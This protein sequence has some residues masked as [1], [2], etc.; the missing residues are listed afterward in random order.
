MLRVLFCMSCCSAPPSNNRPARGKAN[1]TRKNEKLVEEADFKSLLSLGTSEK[2]SL[3]TNQIQANNLNYGAKGT[4]T[5]GTQGDLIAG[6]ANASH[7]HH[8]LDQQSK[9]G[10]DSSTPDLSTAVASASRTTLQS[11]AA[12][13]HQRFA[14][15]PSDDEKSV[16]TPSSIDIESFREHP[17]HNQQFKDQETL[18]QTP[19]ERTVGSE[20]RYNDGFLETRAAADIPS[21]TK[22]GDYARIEYS[23]VEDLDS[24]TTKSQSRGGSERG[25][26]QPSMEYDSNGLRRSSKPASESVSRRSSQGIESTSISIASQLSNEQ[27]Q[28]NLTNMLES[29]NSPIPLFGTIGLPLGPP[30]ESLASETAKT[31]PETT[32]AALTSASQDSLSDASLGSNEAAARATLENATTGAALVGEPS[33][34]GDFDDPTEMARLTQS[35][36][37]AD[38]QSNS[39]LAKESET[40]Q[41]DR[42][43]SSLSMA[44]TT[45]GGVTNPTPT[46]SELSA[47][48]PKKKNKLRPKALLK[49]LKPSG[50]KK[51]KEDTG[52][53][54]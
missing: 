30:L 48:S 8:Q 14:D 9:Q 4:D 24:V 12:D 36:R 47:S 27:F 54:K 33:E 50:K 34:R 3:L 17:E 21:T 42:V 11:I 53:I 16:S 25:G 37:L 13:N 44:T 35:S 45:S 22:I 28:Q 10:N 20:R 19:S 32:G 38:D 40:A 23:P 6:D 15:G 43:D 51:G 46:P 2:E 29:V 7:Q 49:K 5:Q 39:T 41:T 52:N 31:S 1:V 18:E 26:R